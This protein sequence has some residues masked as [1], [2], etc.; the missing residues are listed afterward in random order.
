[1]FCTR[2]IEATIRYLSIDAEKGSYVRAKRQHV[3][4]VV[5]LFSL[6]GCASLPE[7]PTTSSPYAILAFPPT[8][9]LLGLDAQQFDTRFAVNRL[10]VSPGQHTLQLVYVATGP[11]S[12]AAHH[13]QH[14]AP[15]TLEVQEGT[16]YHFMAKT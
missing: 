12:S 11:G 16:T 8:I 6:L 9:Q 13:G 4:C 7:Q 5:G 3:L 2:S 10:R 15:F 1:M 14:I